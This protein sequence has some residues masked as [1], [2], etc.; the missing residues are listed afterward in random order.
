[1]D[2]TGMYCE[3][4]DMSAVTSRSGSDKFELRLTPEMKLGFARMARRRSRKVVI[5]TLGTINGRRGM[6]A[7]PAPE[8]L[9]FCF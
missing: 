9:Y 7:C 4:K 8:G 5:Y 6:K 1:M 3:F 2:K